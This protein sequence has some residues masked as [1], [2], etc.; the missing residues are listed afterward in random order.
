MPFIIEYMQIPCRKLVTCRD[1][2]AHED[3]NQKG[4]FNSFLQEMCIKA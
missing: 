1:W 2:F 4:F 3:H